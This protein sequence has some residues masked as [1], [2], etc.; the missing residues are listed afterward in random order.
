MLRRRRR[1]ATRASG[2]RD[3]QRNERMYVT[4]VVSVLL[5]TTLVSLYDMFLLVSLMNTG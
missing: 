3:T 5:A 4:L 1:V 2:K